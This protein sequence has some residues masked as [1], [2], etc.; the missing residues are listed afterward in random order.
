MSGCV[1]PKVD[2]VSIF[3]SMILNQMNV[4][5]LRMQSCVLPGELLCHPHLKPDHT[6]LY[7]TVINTCV[8]LHLIITYKGVLP[9]N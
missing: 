9:M 6:P 3:R 4:W 7:Y 2:S 5:T 1:S 8:N